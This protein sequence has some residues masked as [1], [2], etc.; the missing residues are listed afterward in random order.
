MINRVIYNFK[1]LTPYI[2]HQ[3]SYVHTSIIHLSKLAKIN[4]SEQRRNESGKLAG[5]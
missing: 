5:K 1:I 2:I 4:D 3:T